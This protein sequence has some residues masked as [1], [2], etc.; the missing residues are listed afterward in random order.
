[1]PV[2]S[3][4]MCTYN[5]QNS[6]QKSIKCLQNQTFKDWELIIIDDGSTDNTEEV[7][8]SFKDTRI[9]YIKNKHDF[10]DSRNKM[11]KH[12]SG[13][14]I[15]ILDSGDT[16]NNIDRL[17][18]CYDYLESHNIDG[19][20]NTFQC[21]SLQ[22]K[23]Y[24][25]LFKKFQKGQCGHILASI[26]IKNDFI[27][28]IP[29]YY[30]QE[31]KTGGEDQQ[32]VKVLIHCLN[33]KIHSIDYYKCKYRSNKTETP[34]IWGNGQEISNNLDTNNIKNLFKKYVK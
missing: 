6:I 29:I 4:C 9:K 34:S 19:I 10:I 20:I 33:K 26:F 22:L 32:F 23:N 21:D 7:I 3:I 5:R 25:E 30:F 24:G 8:K 13:K 31:F 18:F 27:K 16:Y 2:I 28:E 14:Y 15:T 11:F 1:M 17:Q 12:T